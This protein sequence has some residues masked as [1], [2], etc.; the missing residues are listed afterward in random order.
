MAAIIP[1]GRWKVKGGPLGP[2]LPG[3]HGQARP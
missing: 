3:K 1:A 2:A